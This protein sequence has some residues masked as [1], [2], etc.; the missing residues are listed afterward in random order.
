MADHAPLVERA[1]SIEVREGSADLS[2]EG[3]LPSHLSG[4]AYWNGP[5]RFV[6]GDLHYRHWLDGDGLICAL[7]FSGG[8]ARVTTR[9]VRSGKFLAEE[10]AARPLFRQFGTAFPGDQLKRGIGLESPANVSAYPNGSALL[11]FGEQGLPWALDPHTLETRGLFTFDGQLNEITP[12][13]AHPKFDPR[14][15]EM[16]NFGVAFA[17]DRPTL[18]LFRF[19]ATGTLVYR[20]R[21]RL[22][23]PASIHDFALSTSFNVFYV[24]PLL[25]DMRA[26]LEGG[27]TIMDALSWEPQRGSHLLVVSRESGELVASLPIGHKYCLH[28]VNAFESAGRLIVDVVEYE[29]P[30]YDQYQ[31]IPSLFTEVAT[32]APVRYLVDV[33]EA[34]VVSRQE[35]PYSC[36][37]DFPAHDLDLTGQPYRDFWML[38]ISATGRP[39]RKFLDQLVRFDWDTREVEIY[40][41]PALTYLGGEPLFLPDPAAGRTGVIVCQSFDAERVASSFVVF[42]GFNVARGPIATLRLPSPVPLLFHSSYL[43]DRT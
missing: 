4:T 42:D 32:A 16:F 3:V 35:L 13:S 19:D 14:T 12:F 41:A 15:G 37:P 38:G 31:V 39:G 7:A 21:H 34:R 9:F 18:N 40:Q 23:Y 11:A 25:L 43:P 5:G 28:L 8:R 1:F 10:S 33:K 17:A 36:A 20:R 27:A 29:R 30:I 6:R 2:V 24:S 26:F 22:P